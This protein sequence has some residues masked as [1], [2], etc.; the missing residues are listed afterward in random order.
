MCRLVS[1]RTNLCHWR[2]SAGPGRRRSSCRRCRCIGTVSHGSTAPGR[3]PYRPGSG[4][5]APARRRRPRRPYSSWNQSS[6]RTGHCG[7]YIAA[8]SRT[9][10]GHPPWCRPGNRRWT[11]H[12]WIHPVAAHPERA[13]AGRVQPVRRPRC[14]CRRSGRPSCSRQCA[15]SS[16]WHCRRTIGHP[17]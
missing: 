10:P 1:G 3:R 17:T 7:I 2:S 9:R 12:G 15:R 16:G 5:S 4:R 8:G 11:S 14:S 6:Y 13:Y